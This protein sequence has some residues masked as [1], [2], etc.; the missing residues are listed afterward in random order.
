MNPELAA[1]LRDIHELDPVSW[2]PLAPGWWLV[3]LLGLFL[4]Y[5]FFSLLRNLRRYPAGSWNRDAWKQLR[6]LKQQSPGMQ[7]RQLAGALSEL[8][9]RIAVARA[10][11][12]DAAS[13]S[14][15]DW[16]IWLETND[17]RG[18]PW[19]R[20]GTP[21]LRMPYAPPTAGDEGSRAQLME[22]LDALFPW[23]RTT[24]EPAR[25]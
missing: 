23:T 22:L 19:T 11:R 2:W 13:L 14:G 16:L 25:D 12:E 10:G 24:R 4:L 7:P 21:L 18:Y 8:A 20:N 15:E 5:L 6:L 9:R 1:Q 17:P 3:F